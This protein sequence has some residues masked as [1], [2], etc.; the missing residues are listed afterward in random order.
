ML[1]DDF[2]SFGAQEYEFRR[3]P[4]TKK[5]DQGLFGPVM[6]E[7]EVIVPPSEGLMGGLERFYYYDYSG[8]PPFSGILHD[9]LGVGLAVFAGFSRRARCL[10]SLMLATGVAFVPEVVNWMNGYLESNQ[11]PLQVGMDIGKVVVGY[12]VGRFLC[13]KRSSTRIDDNLTRYETPSGRR[14]RKWWPKG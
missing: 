5:H 11:V 13:F 14:L 4:G 8:L 2:R 9:S 6:P 1:G 10:S 7:E 12:S 3:I